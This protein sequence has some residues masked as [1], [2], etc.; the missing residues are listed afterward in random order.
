MLNWCGWRRLVATLALG[1]AGMGSAHA[2][3]VTGDAD[4]EFGP[5]VPGISYRADFSFYLPDAVLALAHATATNTIDINADNIYLEGHVW[6]YETANPLNISSPG[7]FKFKLQTVTFDLANDLLLNW[8]ATDLAT[9]GAPCYAGYNMMPLD[10]FAPGYSFGFEWPELAQPMQLTCYYGCTNPDDSPTPARTANLYVDYTY[11]DDEGR[12]RP[13]QVRYD[14]D[15]NGNRR[16]TVSG[17]STV[18]EPAS[19]GLVLLALAGLGWQQ[20]RR[21]KR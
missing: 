15:G 5:A 8:Q 6:L 10:A 3:L 18:P 13:H 2:G 20:R 7:T 19:A 4:P 9:C 12:A 17:L 11:R 14:F 21:S 1:V 16:M